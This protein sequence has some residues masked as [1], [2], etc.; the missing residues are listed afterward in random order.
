MKKQ[1]IQS[2]KYVMRLSML[3][4]ISALA[5]MLLAATTIPFAARAAEESKEQVVAQVRSALEAQQAAW[6]RGDID[7]FTTTYDRDAIF[8]SGDEITRGSQTILER[9]K[10]KYSDRAKMGTLTFSDLEITALGESAAVVL[11][12]WSLKRAN[13]EPHGRFT[14]IFRKTPDSWRIVHDHTSSAQ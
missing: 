6:N 13:D 10:K 2:S 11:G 4:T 8:V 12:R 9:Y 5:A 1:P 7:T 3:R 14:L